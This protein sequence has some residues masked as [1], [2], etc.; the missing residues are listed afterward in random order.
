[1]AASASPR[2]T[3]SEFSFSD[4]GL[5]EDFSVEDEYI[6]D[7]YDSEPLLSSQADME[8]SQ[9]EPTRRYGGNKY[10]LLKRD[11]AETN[12]IIPTKWRSRRC[13]IRI[14]VVLLS[15]G[16]GIMCGYFISRE[17]IPACKVALLSHGILGNNMSEPSDLES[18]HVQIINRISSRSMK[19]FLR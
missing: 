11:E 15:C 7:D 6:Y 1:M 4:V 10:S 3:Q 16:F 17:Y 14:F 5:R 18:L 2:G 13:V 8:L 12:T 19:G 9:Q